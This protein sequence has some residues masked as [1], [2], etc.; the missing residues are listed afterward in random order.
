MVSTELEQTI[1]EHCR[2]SAS[3]CK[4]RVSFE[5]PHASHVLL[6]QAGLPWPTDSALE[7]RHLVQGH[8]LHLEDD[9][10]SP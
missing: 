1:R 4:W 5:E 9:E 3:V 6:R 2:V 7:D 8:R 10:Y